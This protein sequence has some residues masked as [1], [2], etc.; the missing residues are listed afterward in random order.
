MPNKRRKRT[1]VAAVLFFLTFHSVIRGKKKIPPND[2]FAARDLSRGSEVVIWAGR[3]CALCSLAGTRP[4]ECDCRRLI[5]RA[6]GNVPRSFSVFFGI[7]EE[8]SQ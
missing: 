5:Y 3:D 4:C 1:A 7:L 6:N 8:F 2:Y